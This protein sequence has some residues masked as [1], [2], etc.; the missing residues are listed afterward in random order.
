MSTEEKRAHP[1]FYFSTFGLFFLLAA[2]TYVVVILEIGNLNR[3]VGPVG[4][5]CALSILAIIKYAHPVFTN[6]ERLSLVIIIFLLAVPFVRGHDSFRYI[7]KIQVPNNYVQISDEDRARMPRL[8]NGFIIKDTLNYLNWCY[9]FLEKN[10]LW[11][12]DFYFAYYLPNFIL[13]IGAPGAAAHQWVP[14][15]YNSSKL[16]FDAF[17]YK[18]YS[19]IENN[20]YINY[21]LVF[22][23][24]VVQTPEGFWV[25]PE[26][27]EGKYNPEDL[28]KPEFRAN[29]GL[30][31][32]AYGRS[33]K[34]LRPIFESVKSIY[35]IEEFKLGINGTDADYIYIELETDI[36][37]KNNNF[38]PWDFTQYGI[39]FSFKHNGQWDSYD[40]PYGDGRLLLPVGD[41]S[42][43]LYEYIEEIAVDLDKGFLPDTRARMKKMELLKLKRYR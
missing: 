35:D 29:M 8:G 43:W 16:Y 6:K 17:K 34:S 36:K 13:N 9:N 28:K 32:V 25:S 7:N 10:K 26:L 27:V 1:L 20:R 12:N 15:G 5:V 31:S 19:G 4:I 40:I 38:E 37:I 30:Y 39:R 2:Y 18:P 33:M 22:D 14:Q 23:K 41:D 21:W 3:A 24:G 42:R 11:D